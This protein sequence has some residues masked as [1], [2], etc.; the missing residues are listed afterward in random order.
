MRLRPGQVRGATRDKAGCLFGLLLQLFVGEVGFD[1]SNRAAAVL[2]DGYAETGN[3][4]I[5]E[6]EQ[7]A[8]CDGGIELADLECHVRDGAD[9]GVQGTIRL[10]A[11]PLNAQCFAGTVAGAQSKQL[12]K[13]LSGFR[14]DVGMP[15]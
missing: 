13:S 10:E 2:N 15:R 1:Q 14:S 7:I 5:R 8:T 9:Q 12:A 3:G 4:L 6:N 11:V